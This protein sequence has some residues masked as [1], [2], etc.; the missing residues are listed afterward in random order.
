VFSTAPA[1]AFAPPQRYA[2]GGIYR[3][4]IFF[5]KIAVTGAS[6]GASG[7]KTRESAPSDSFLRRHGTV[8]GE[9]R[10]LFSTATRRLEDRLRELRVCILERAAHARRL[11]RRIGPAA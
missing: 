11:A 3:V 9:A 10:D 5:A 8:F 2:R 4:K 1:R 7:R 6:S